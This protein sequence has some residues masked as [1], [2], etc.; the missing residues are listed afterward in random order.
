[1]DQILFKFHNSKDKDA[2]IWAIIF[3]TKIN[4]YHVSYSK[5]MFYAFNNLRLNKT[6]EIEIF[7][8]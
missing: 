6:I 1:M 4:F 2:P 3:Q 8:F 7:V 5:I